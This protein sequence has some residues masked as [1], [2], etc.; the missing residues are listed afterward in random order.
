MISLLNY[1]V[2]SVEFDARL[3]QAEMLEEIVSDKLA[4]L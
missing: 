2:A 3:P 4:C 1:D